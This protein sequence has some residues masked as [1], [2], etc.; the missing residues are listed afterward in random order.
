MEL[1]KTVA[2]DSQTPINRLPAE[3]L[4]QIFSRCLPQGLPYHTPKTVPLVL[5]EVCT[6]WRILVQSLPELWKSLSIRYRTPTDTE[7]F[8]TGYPATDIIQK[9]CSHGNPIGISCYLDIRS[10]RREDRSAHAFTDLILNN[11]ESFR[12]LDIGLSSA[13]TFERLFTHPAGKFQV[14]ESLGLFVNGISWPSSVTSFADVPRLRR[15]KLDIA[16]LKYSES[17]SFLHIPWQ[18][19]THLNIWKTRHLLDYNICLGVLE[20]CSNVE[21]VAISV[22]VFFR[23]HSRPFCLPCLRSL[24]LEIRDHTPNFPLFQPLQAPALRQLFI[25]A[26]D[27]PLHPRWRDLAHF[28]EQF[29]S[30]TSLGLVHVTMVPQQ[31]LSFLTA[32]PN[33]IEISLKPVWD[34]GLHDWAHIVKGLTISPGTQPIVPHLKRLTL[35]EVSY[36]PYLDI[37]IPEQ[38][39]NMI[40]SRWSFDP[41]SNT[42]NVTV[43][44]LGYC[45]GFPDINIKEI[46][47]ERGFECDNKLNVVYSDKYTIRPFFSYTGGD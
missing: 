6:A 13:M 29:H 23:Q 16:I 10:M 5:C 32:N 30:L 41:L 24:S 33:L 25:T 15:L 1:S 18:Q 12:R 28:A 22:S 38:Y 14:L 27:Y 43:F 35:M 34:T 2:S 39:A 42:Q 19:L 3:V 46:L 36:L 11:S 26:P 8:G 21:E 20:Q 31:L 40:A 4:A 45:E 37:I 47:M 44:T 9:W 17:S 7:H